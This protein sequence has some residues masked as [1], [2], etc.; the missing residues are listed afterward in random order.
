MNQ[1]M[2]KDR[3]EEGE[4]SSEKNAE[5]LSRRRN[6]GLGASGWGSFTLLKEKADSR[7]GRPVRDRRERDL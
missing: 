4:S 7:P 6:N 2:P 3:R 5:S 1:P